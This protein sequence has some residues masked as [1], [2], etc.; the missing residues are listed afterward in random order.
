ME[1]TASFLELSGDAY[2]LLEGQGVKEGRPPQFVTPLRPD[3]VR[4]V[5]DKKNKVGRYIYSVGQREMTLLP[6]EVLHLQ[7]FSPVKDYLGQGSIEPATMAAVVDL[8]AVHFNKQFFRRGAVLSGVISTDEELDAATL[9]RLVQSFRDQ[10]AGSDRAWDVKGLSHNLKFT[11]VQPTHHDMLF[12]NLR[13]MNREEILMAMG[14]PPVMVTVLDEATYNNV[15]EQKRQFWELTVLPKLRKLEERINKDLASRYGPDISVKF[16]LSDVAAL[17]E[18]RKAIADTGAVMVT[19]GALTQNE[20]RE[21]MSTGDLPV[22]DPIQGGDVPLLPFTLMPAGEAPEPQEA[23]A[24]SAPKDPL[25]A[26]MAD[27]ETKAKRILGHEERSLRRKAIW[28]AFD[29]S[30]RTFARVFQRTANAMFTEQE[31]A[32]LANLEET[33]SRSLDTTGHVRKGIA[34]ID[35]LIDA[36]QNGNIV[37]FRAVYQQALKVAGDGALKDLGIDAI[38]FSLA[39]PNVLRFLDAEG[40]KLVTNVDQTTKN[41]LASALAEGISSGENALQLSDRVR[42]VFDVSRGRA[43]TIGRTESI[44]SF[45]FGAIEAYKQTDGLVDRKRWLATQDEVTREAHSEAD[46]QVVQLNESFDVGG[47]HLGYP[48]DPSNGDPGNTVNCRCTV[49]PIL[50]G[51]AGDVGL[52]LNP[53]A[54]RSRNGN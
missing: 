4:I 53:G 26:A 54:G 2:W 52:S 28:R 45:N 14:V 47:D 48:G 11:P 1:S 16:D 29:R 15:K 22:L 44:K 23:P 46:G 3:R 51:E 42:G 39:N 10:H 5:G 43:N 38:D 49:E 17:K 19:H 27:V 32:V 41:Q 34:E 50:A 24:L 37:R 8:W 33:L 31:R 35:L 21:W 36:L 18:D 25:E 12:E 7:Y 30:T 40:A 13:R 20:F 9:D 6:T